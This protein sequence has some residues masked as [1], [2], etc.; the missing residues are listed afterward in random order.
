M[1]S[2]LLAVQAGVDINAGDGTTLVGSGVSVFL[3]TLIVGAV[4]LGTI[5]RDYFG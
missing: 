4:G 3:T 2:F 1:N 5:L